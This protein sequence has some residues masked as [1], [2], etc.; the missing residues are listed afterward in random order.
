VVDE[1]LTKL[2]EVS[3]L[4][5]SYADDMAYNG[6]NARENF[7]SILKDCMDTFCVAALSYK[8]YRFSDRI[9]LKS[10]D[11]EVKK[12]N[13]FLSLVSNIS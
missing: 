7:L 1:L 10:E 4:V 12:V 13:I 9:F 6:Y 8:R 2:R 11:L 5:F 3:F